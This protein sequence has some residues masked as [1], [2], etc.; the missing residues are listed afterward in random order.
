MTRGR[1][2]KATKKE[3]ATL[4]NIHPPIGQP[5]RKTNQLIYLTRTIMHALIRHNESWPF[6]ELITPQQIE[7]PNYYDIV[8]RP[9]SLRVVKKRLMNNYYL[10]AYE[11]IQDISLVFENAYRVTAPESAMAQMAR[12]METLFRAH[13]QVMPEPEMEIELNDRL[14]PIRRVH[15]PHNPRY[16]DNNLHD[17]CVTSSDTVVRFY[18]VQNDI[19][20]IH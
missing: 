5:I 15:I 10:S 7:I 6:L 20:R 3:K 17:Q 8:T 2:K 14:A 19:L 18:I 16:T 4:L 13:L 11:A 1:P 9:M 12:N